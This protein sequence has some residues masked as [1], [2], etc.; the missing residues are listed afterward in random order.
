VSPDSTFGNGIQQL[1]CARL[2][3][4]RGGNDFLI[5]PQN[6]TIISSNNKNLIDYYRSRK[7]FIWGSSGTV[8]SGAEIQEQY[9]KY[10]FDFSKG[11]PH[12]KNQVKYNEPIIEADEN[13]QFNQLI[14]ILTEQAAHESGLPSLVFCRNIN[15]AT[16]LF[17]KLKALNSNNESLQLYTGLGKEE[18]YIKN[19]GKRGMITITTSALGRN[20][21]INYDRDK[22]LRV[23]HTF[24]DSIRGMGQKSGRTGRQGSTGEVSFIFN[25]QELGKKSIEQI[26]DQIDKFMELERSDNEALYNVLG[27]LLTKLDSLREEQF[28]K[29]KLAFLRD[30]WAKFSTDTETLFK[31]S[32]SEGVY[33]QVIFIETTLAKFNSILNAALNT[34]IKEITLNDLSQIIDQRHPEKIKYKPYKKDIK[35]RDCTPPV[36]IAYHLLQFAYEDKQP[37]KTKKAVKEKISQIFE[38]MQKNMFPTDNSKHLNEYLQFLISN[39]TT[40]EVIVDAHKEFL[41]QYL[42][43]HS[44]KLNILQRWLG[45][46]GKLNQIASNQSYLLM[47]H[48]FASISNKSA[49]ELE[50][51]KEGVRSLLD[52]YLETAWFVS[53]ERRTWAM[54]L[55][56]MLNGSQDISQVIDHLSQEHIE[57]A[58]KDVNTNKHRFLKSLHI[59]GHSRY[60]TTLKRAVNLAT[61]L[62]GKTDVNELTKGLIPLMEQVTDHTPVT[63]LTLDELKHRAESKKID[64]NNAAVIIDILENTLSIKERENQKGMMGRGPKG[65]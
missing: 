33:D 21:N 12:Q 64:I 20:T 62:S 13:A 31:K 42:Q 57:V 11:E 61:S 25:A 56:T 41:M 45:Y 40:Q 59:F 35:L 22:G 30:S 15:T 46:E 51:I 55:K 43:D 19:A 58:K 49:T 34:S 32:R 23:W 26:Q 63:N 39:P 17:N 50:V 14:S 36:T 29:G 48:A 18:D 16:R 65:T 47:F 24:V 6:K 28:L 54:Q 5:E 52:E 38:R 53:S 27:Y 2:N 1:L 9:S 37:E 44:K 4:E 8:G 60:Q 10:G 7:G 3:T